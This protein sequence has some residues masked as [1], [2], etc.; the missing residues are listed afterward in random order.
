MGDALTVLVAVGVR[1]C[2]DA[3]RVRLRVLPPDR[4]ALTPRLPVRVSVGL[5]DATT[6]SD[7][8]A[9][10]VSETEALT[11]VEG[12]GVSVSDA[13]SPGLCEFETLAP[14][15]RVTEAVAVLLVVGVSEGVPVQLLLR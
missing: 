9:V 2:L 14:A 10:G 12:S 1:A 11:E 13:V 5:V 3:E 8:L 6:D 4:E 7:T 15:P